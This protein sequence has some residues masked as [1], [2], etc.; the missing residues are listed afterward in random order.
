MREGAAIVDPRSAGRFARGEARAPGRGARCRTVFRS[1]YGAAEKL[2]EI[3]TRAGGAPP[4]SCNL[5]CIPGRAMRRSWRHIPCCATHR[6]ACVLAVLR[7]SVPLASGRSA[8]DP[9]SRWSPMPIGLSHEDGNI[10][11][12]EIGGM[13]RS[14]ELHD[15]Q[16]LLAGRMA[17]TGPVRLLVLLDRFEGWDPRDDWRDLAFYATHGDDIE[18]IAIVGPDAWMA[19]MLAFAAAD[20]RKGPVEFFPGDGMAN[21][22]AWLLAAPRAPGP[23]ARSFR[24]DTDT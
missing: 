18:R 1:P 9:E 8:R 11:R 21:A 10:Y 16:Q 5:A 19:H 2:G 6:V 17:D 22:R 23:A 24:K 15:C 12:V 14:R 13:L 3:D 7:H 4:S 20:L